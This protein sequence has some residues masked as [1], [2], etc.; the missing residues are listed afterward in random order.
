MPSLAVVPDIHM[1]PSVFA[2]AVALEAE[3]H[4]VV[5]LGDYADNGPRPNDAGFLREVLGFCRET[6]T[7]P[8]IGNHDLAYLF[9]EDEGFRQNGFEPD[10]LAALAEVY[11]EYR[12]ELRYAFRKQKYLCSHAG[13]SGVFM[14]VMESKYGVDTVD[15]LIAFLHEEEPPEL[16]YQSTHNDGQAAFDGPLWLRLPQYRGALEAE[17][18]TQ[19]VGHSS[20]STIRVKHN[21]IMIDVRLPLLLE[22]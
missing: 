18:I 22:W 10:S 9:P 5:L 11:A 20:Q 8:L 2:H 19:V 21:L 12:P 7:V 1:R 13:F 17:G 3:G 4:Q 6:G 16:Y 14:R 15:Q